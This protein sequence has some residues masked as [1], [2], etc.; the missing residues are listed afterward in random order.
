MHILGIDIGGTGIKGA[1]VDTNKGELLAER[2]RLLTPQPATP[3]SVATTVAELV[4][5]FEWTGDIGCGFPAVIKDGVAYTAAN[6][7]HSW[8]GTDA[9]E[10]L[11]SRTGCDVTVLNDADAAGLAE[12][13][14]G[15]GR[16]VQGVVLLVTLGTGIGSALF[17]D[18]QLIPNT[19]L[20]HIEFRGRDAELRASD[21]A[22]LEHD[23]SWKSWAK[24]VDMYLTSLHNVLWP[25]L[26]IIGGG[27]SKNSARFFPYLTVKTKVVPAQFLNDAGIVGAA[28]AAAMVSDT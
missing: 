13:R 18:G 8:I 25:D 14:F 15:A 21:R 9:R 28:L 20:G 1:P 5:R 19:E 6:V 24:R 26:I 22:R 11:E 27:V 16:D 7:D 10:L 3:D 17:I 4:Q 23:W 2:L 12:V